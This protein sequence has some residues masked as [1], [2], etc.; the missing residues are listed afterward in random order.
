MRKVSV[1]L[2][3]A[4]LLTSACGVALQDQEATSSRLSRAS[5]CDGDHN[6]Q[7]GTN[8]ADCGP[9]SVRVQFE[10]PEAPGD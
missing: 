9:T 3:V 8:F 4:A 7:I 5:H 6:E 10:H 2:I 1:V